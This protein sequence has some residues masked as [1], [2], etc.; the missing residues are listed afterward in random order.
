MD[1]IS[2]EVNEE[3]IQR[4]TAKLI[5]IKKEAE[6]LEKA[7]DILKNNPDYSILFEAMNH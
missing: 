3:M 7:I 2:I 5:K 6:I 4:L 1:N